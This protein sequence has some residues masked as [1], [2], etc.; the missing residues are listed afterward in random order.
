MLCHAVCLDR[1]THAGMKTCHLRQRWKINRIYNSINDVCYPSVVKEMYE[2]WRWL[3]QRLLKEYFVQK[4]WIYAVLLPG[5]IAPQRRVS[6][7]ACTWAHFNACV[8][9]ACTC[10]YASVWLRASRCEVPPWASPPHHV[11]TSPCLM[12][13]SDTRCLSLLIFSQTTKSLQNPAKKDCE[14]LFLQKWMK[15]I[16][17]PPP[18]PCWR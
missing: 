8:C 2:W 10:V 15:A 13:G 16:F 17:P 7:R 5:V 14:N 4:F 1:V 6:E 9:N 11:S 3:K 12:S 18:Q